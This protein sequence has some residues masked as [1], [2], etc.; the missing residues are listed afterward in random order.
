[1]TGRAPRVAFSAVVVAIALVLQLT[2]VSRLPLPGATPD[3][4]LVAVVSLALSRGELHGC[5]TGFCAG[6]AL[7]LAP[8]ADHAVGRWALVLCGLGYLAGRL[9]REAEQSAFVPLIVVAAAAAIGTLAFAVLGAIVDSS[10]ISWSLLA[11]VLP[12]AVIYDV[13]IAPFVVLVVMGLATR[14][15]DD[16]TRW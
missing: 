6:L 10:N 9:R 7:D 14:I 11:S 15:G 4:V 1:M 12:S 13:V 2:V 5:V 16:P 8:P 3:L